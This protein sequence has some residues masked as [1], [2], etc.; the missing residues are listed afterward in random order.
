MNEVSRIHLGRQ[1][2][3]IAADAHSDLKAYLSAI[4]KKAQDEEVMNEVELRMSEL[5]LERGVSGDKVVLPADVDFIKEQLGTPADFSSD[6]SD[7]AD[8]KPEP[9]NA[10]K[11][12]FRD[13]DRALVGGVAAGI[14]NYFGLEPAII[15]LI[16]VVLIFG[17]GSGL[18]LYLLLW[19]AIPPA[20]STSEKLQMKGKPVTLEALKESVNRADVPAA[21]RRVNK[22]VLSVIDGLFRVVVKVLGVGFILSGA[23]LIFGVVATRLYM[24]LHN[25]RLFQENIFP[26]GFREQLLLW[27]GMGVF[28]IVSVFILLI[29]VATLRRKWP[30]RSWITG[31]LAGLLMLGSVTTAVLVADAVPRVRERYQTTLHTTAVKDIQPFS[32]VVTEGNIDIEYIS[33]PSYGVTVHYSDN[34]DLTKLKV[35]VKD[36]VLYVDSRSLDATDHCYMLCLFPRYNM[37]V[38]IFAPTVKDFTTPP[39]TDIFFPTVPVAPA[40]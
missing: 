14:A 1:P 20:T 28:V 15:R 2:F 25:G 34:P 13:T 37:T 5:L 40:Q 27:L 16:F 24:I 3:T 7:K 35:L 11:R 21:A 6:E 9:S 23:V 10:A 33:A 31:V 30:V 39:R 32:K 4:K 12:L 17:G 18:I 36:K 19:L 26:V 38:Q 8:D 29:G 22:T